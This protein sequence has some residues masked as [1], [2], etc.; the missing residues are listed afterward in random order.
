M[1]EKA[2]QPSSCSY[3]FDVLRG[4]LCGLGLEQGRRNEKHGPLPLADL[5]EGCLYVADLGFFGVQRLSAIAH[6]EPGHKRIKRY[7]VSRYQAKTVLQTRGG[8][9]I[10]LRGILPRQEGQVVEVGA[11]LGQVGRLAV[12]VLM[13][14]VSQEVAEQRRARIREAAQAQGRE[15]DAEVLYLAQWTIVLTNVPRRRLSTE[16]VWVIVRLRGPLE[17]LF[18]LWKEHGYLDEWREPRSR[19]AS[20]VRCMPNWRRWCSSSG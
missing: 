3:G 19:G 5:P 6:G 9:R 10:E 11:L 13:Q 15:P 14:R 18:K 4:E 7:F 1:Q 8:H 20:Y 12:R 17:L 16:Q 2:R